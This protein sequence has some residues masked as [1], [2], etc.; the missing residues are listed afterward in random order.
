MYFTHTYFHFKVETIGDGYLCVSGLPRRNGNRHVK[1]I[2]DMALTFIRM[3]ASVTVPHLPNE[4]INLRIG[5]N[6]GTY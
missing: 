5:I 6:T 3:I 4:R 1:E 2:A